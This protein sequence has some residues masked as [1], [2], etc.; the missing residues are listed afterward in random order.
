MAVDRPGN[1]LAKDNLVRIPVRPVRVL[2]VDPTA[3]DQGEL[4][5]TLFVYP[6]LADGE[7]PD[8]AREYLTGRVLAISEDPMA[9]GGPAA[10]AQVK[11]Q[12]IEGPIWIDTRLLE[13]TA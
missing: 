7:E 9:T 12:G 5:P 2:Q 1:P 8:A 11:V 4:T 6:G 13:K 10:I 3:W